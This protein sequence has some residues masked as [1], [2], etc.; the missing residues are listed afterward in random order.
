MNIAVNRQTTA[1]HQFTQTILPTLPQLSTTNK[2]FGL[3]KKRPSIG[4]IAL[5]RMAFGPRPGDL[6]A[7]NALGHDDTT[8]LN[9]YIEQQL[10]SEQIDDASLNGRIH[11]ASFKT[12]NKPRE[13]LW[14]DHYLAGADFHTRT[15]AIREL[16]RLKFVRAI[17]SEHQLIEVLADF[18]HDHFNIYARHSPQVA[19]TFLAYDRDIIRTHLLG[20][21]R[22]LLGTVM[23]SPEL[24]HYLDG[25]WELNNEFSTPYVLELLT[26]Y[27]VGATQS[28]FVSLPANVVSQKINDVLLDHLATH[29]FTAQNIC[30]KLCQRL[31]SD[32][33]PSRLVKSATYQFITHMESPDQLKVVVAHILRSTE[34]QSTWGEKVKRPFESIVSA[35]RATNLEFNLRCDDKES[36]SFMWRFGQIGHAPFAWNGPDGYPDVK[37]YWQ[38]SSTLIMRWRMINWL[39]ELKDENGRYR[40]KIVE[41]TKTN[42]HTASGLVDYWTNRLLKYAMSLADRQVLVNFMAHGFASNIKLDLSNW[43]VQDRLREMIALI[44][45]TPQFQLR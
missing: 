37:S 8:R 5:N 16:E 2:L 18:W 7:F 35:I 38:N 23:I 1:A 39:V 12:L 40:L 45:N 31:V 43:L 44:L 6:D 21:F 32:T 34:F 36:N 14:Q 29:P 4:I 42:D 24:Y 9:A 25:E 11:A 41:Q 20:N 3:N 13:A 28:G 26:H 22:E 27:T 10:N 19:A 33:P 30:R 17:Y 15:L